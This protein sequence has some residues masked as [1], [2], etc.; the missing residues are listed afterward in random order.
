M[1][2][3]FLSV[4]QGANLISAR[5]MQWA[6]KLRPKDRKYGERLAIL[7]KMHSSEAFAGC[8]DALE[9]VVFSVMVEVI[10]EQERA[11]EEKKDPAH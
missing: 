10:R 9:A 8:D 6:R 7:A 3:S 4:R 5:W 11:G 1:G 2:R